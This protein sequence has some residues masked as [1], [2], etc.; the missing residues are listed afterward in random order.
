MRRIPFF[1]LFTL[2]LL[3]PMVANAASIANIGSVLCSGSLSSSMTEIASFLC[4]GDFALFDGSISSGSKVVITADGSLFLDNLS[5]TA[6]VI[7][8][9]ALNGGIYAWDAPRNGNSVLVSG[10][11]NPPGAMLLASG[12]ADHILNIS[13]P[14]GP[15]DIPL[16]IGGPITTTPVPEPSTCLLMLFGILGLVGVRLDQSSDGRK[17]GQACCYLLNIR[18]SFPSSS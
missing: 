15:G 2:L 17:R 10:G 13:L 16:L 18:Y 6:P 3:S 12:R 4:S 8:L 7:E 9:T 5:I 1:M 11:N 14:I